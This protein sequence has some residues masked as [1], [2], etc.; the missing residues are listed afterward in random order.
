MSLPFYVAVKRAQ[1]NWWFWYCEGR[2]VVDVHKSNHLGEKYAWKIV[3]VVV[4]SEKA[5]PGEI[6][7]RKTEDLGN[8][9]TVCAGAA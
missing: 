6:D 3:V 7:A 9:T 5:A 2:K 1:T 8:S 4:S